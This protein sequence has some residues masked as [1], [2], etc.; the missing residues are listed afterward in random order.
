[1]QIWL[2]NEADTVLAVALFFATLPF[3]FFLASSF[4]AGSTK[5]FIAAAA[6]PYVVLSIPAVA[7]TASAI[8]LATR[9]ILLP[10]FFIEPFSFLVAAS[11]SSSF[12]LLPLTSEP[13]LS[14]RTKWSSV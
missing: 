10:A 6:F 3:D 14:I 8:V 4:L 7:V 9:L 13:L 2:F 11:A 1:M 12:F 5:E